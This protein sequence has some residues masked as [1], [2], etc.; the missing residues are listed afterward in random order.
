MDEMLGPN[1]RRASSVVRHA[2]VDDISDR[3][4]HGAWETQ[5]ELL[6]ER[7]RAFFDAT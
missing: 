5:A 1:T 2:T 6:A 3:A 4:G 7:I